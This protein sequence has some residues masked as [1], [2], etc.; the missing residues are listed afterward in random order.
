MNDKSSKILIAFFSYALAVSA[1]AL[2]RHYFPGYSLPFSALLLVFLAVVF[3][4][5][6]TGLNFSLKGI[7]LGFGASAF[8]LIPYVF[9]AG[10]FN[11][12]S[13]SLTF[14]LYQM[15]Y[16]AIPEELFFRGYLQRTTEEVFKSRILSVILVSLI[17]A[18]AH[19]LTGRGI[20]SLLTFFPSLVMGT[21]FA[22]T[23]SVVPGIIFHFFANVVE[24]ACRPIFQF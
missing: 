12:K 9:I 21:L 8:F 20:Y 7:L 1:T 16:V 6:R 3:S 11:I 5:G 15:L 14:F 23:R 24:A 2:L 17:F 22:T 10:N 18:L 19:L 4:K 13:L